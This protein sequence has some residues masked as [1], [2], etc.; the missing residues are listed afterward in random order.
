MV[1]IVHAQTAEHYECIRILFLQ[2]AESLDFDLGFQQFDD[3]LNALPGDYAPPD[4]CVILAEDDGKWA[5]CVAL[6]RLEEGICEMKRLYVLPDFQGRGIGRFLAQAVID[7]ARAKGY[8][9]MRLD[10]VES[11]HAARALYVSLGFYAI[12]PYRYNPIDGASFMELT[13]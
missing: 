1:R 5:G 12:E 9:K 2:Y 6:R 10:T 8:A 3:E 13:L 7:E 11:M 4:G